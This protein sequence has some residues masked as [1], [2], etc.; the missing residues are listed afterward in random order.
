MNLLICDESSYE[1]LSFAS[2][3]DSL[4]PYSTEALCIVMNER[5][6]TVFSLD[7]DRR[8]TSL[9]MIANSFDKRGFGI[10]R[11]GKLFALTK[12]SEYAIR[13]GIDNELKFKLNKKTVPQIIFEM[14]GF[15]FK[16][17]RYEFNLDGIEKKRGAIIL[18]IGVGKRWPTK[19]WPDD[20]WIELAKMLKRSGYNPVFTGGEAERNL[21]FDY[22]TRAGI[23]SLPPSS[24]KI[25]AET[26]AAAE[27]VVTCDSL[28]LH[29]AIAVKTYTFGLFCSTSAAEIEW[30]GY[31]EAILSN[32]GPCYNA[33]CPNWPEC[34]KEITPEYLFKRIKEKIT[35]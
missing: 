23:N 27:A 1:V 31:G 19:S 24:L 8:A 14:C 25:F 15:E 34:M 30:Y 5:F 3:I 22:S 4:I 2:N 13:L 11:E 33:K 18:N 21:L 35:L 28:G 32:K 26:L 17:E 9:A 7:K 10:T 29:I 12:D 6:D 20:C 16:N